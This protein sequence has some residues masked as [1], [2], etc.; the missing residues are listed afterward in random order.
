MLC[1]EVVAWMQQ[2]N[3]KQLGELWENMEMILD[4]E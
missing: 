2:E 4:V 3:F 1:E